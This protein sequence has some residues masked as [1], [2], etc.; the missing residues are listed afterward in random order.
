MFDGPPNHTSSAVKSSADPEPAARTDPGRSPARLPARLL[1]VLLPVAILALGIGAFFQ[2]AR[3]AEPVRSSPPPRPALRTAVTE[4]RPR[5]FPVVI[6][7]Q[8]IVQPHQEITLSAQVSGRIEEVSP[9]FETGAYV[10][11]GEVLV[12]LEVRDY[13]IAL[14]IAE[15]RALAAESAHQIA[16]LNHERNQK[17]SAEQLISEAE[18]DHTAA[19]RQQAAAEVASS[20]AQV[21]RARQDLERTRIRAPFAGR[22][23][24]RQ[25]GP[26]QLVG[27]GTPLGA[28]F[29]ID[30]AEVR[31]PLAGRELT[32]LALPEQA[33]DPPLRVELRDALGGNPDTVWEAWI[34]RTEGVL[35]ESSLQLFAIARIDDPFGLTTGRPPLRIAQPVMASITGATLADVYALPRAA[36]RQLDRVL[37]VDPTTLT[38]RSHTITPLW[39]DAHFIIVRDHQIAAG[40]LLATTHLVFAPEGAQVEIIPETDAL[41]PPTAAGTTG[42]NQ[43]PPRKA[44]SQAEVKS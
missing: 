25:V 34:V 44:P 16:R 5:D 10:A 24:E 2:L 33:D 29:A 19:I 27:T 39:S 15:A 42:T 14:T 31:L 43:A 37:L 9:R 11:A 1:R 6:T 32:H 13:E 18:V 35:D 41:Q 38:L 36:V 20:A 22:V 4:L 7:T 23:R 8:G 3:E 12:T 26:G 21:A 17:L 30:F 28:I 40:T